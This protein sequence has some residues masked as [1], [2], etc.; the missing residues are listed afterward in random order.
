MVISQKYFFNIQPINYKL[1]SMNN[2][3][4]IM[5]HDMHDYK[6]AQSLDFKDFKWIKVRLAVS[7]QSDSSAQGRLSVVGEK[8]FF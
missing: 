2:M 6:H 4:E 3:D 5:F 7:S 8:V 1:L